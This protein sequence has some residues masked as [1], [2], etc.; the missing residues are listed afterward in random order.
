[1][2]PPWTARESG[3]NL[4][5]SR[6]NLG[7]SRENLARISRIAENLVRI[8]EKLQNRDSGQNASDPSGQ[9]TRIASSSLTRLTDHSACR[10]G[11]DPSG[12]TTRCSGQTG[13]TQWG[14]HPDLQLFC[15][16]LDFVLYLVVHQHMPITRNW[17]PPG[18]DFGERKSYRH[19]PGAAFS[20][21]GPSRGGAGLR[22]SEQL[23][24]F[25]RTA[26]ESIGI[27]K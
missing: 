16:N 23:L 18:E 24:P 1:M 2:P 22:S 27:T 9:T 21:S 3:E 26:D 6:E 14:N 11:S 17:L 19:I 5:E 7:E 13:Q 20:S 10:I 8:S 25:I 4:G 15:T 12:Q